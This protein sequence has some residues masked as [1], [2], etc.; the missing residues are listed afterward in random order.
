MPEGH[1]DHPS[2]KEL[3]DFG[4]GKLP[5]P[6]AD[7]VAAHLE[8][9]AECLSRLEGQRP[10]SFVGRLRDAAPKGSPATI[11]DA[12]AAPGGFP[13]ELLAMGKF[14]PLGQLGEGGMG[15]VWK[16]RHTFL[17]RLVAIK[18]MRPDVVSSPDARRR[19]LQEMRAG[20]RLGH[21][22]IAQTIDAAES[23]GLLYLV[24]EFV[25]GVSLDKLVS[26]RGP[27]PVGFACRCVVQAAQGLQHAHELGLVHRDVKPANLMVRKDK[28]VKVLDFGLARVPSEDDSARKTRYQVFLGTADY[29][30]PE[31]AKDARSAD[32]RSDIYS[33][34]CTLFFLLS[35]RP[36]FLGKNPYEVAAMHVAQAPAPLAGV[37]AG[38][39]AVVS[40]MMAKRREDRYQTPAEVIEALTPFAA[41]REPDSKP[42]DDSAIRT[43][44]PVTYRPPPLPDPSEDRP[45]LAPPERRPHYLAAALAGLALAAIAWGALAWKRGGAAEVEIRVDPPD[46]LVTVEGPQLSLTTRGDG[47]PIR[48]PVVPGEPY[49][50]KVEKPGFVTQTEPFVY[51]RGDAPVEVRLAPAPPPKKEGPAALP[52]PKAEAPPPKEEGPPDLRAAK[53]L[54]HDEFDDPKTSLP[55]GKDDHQERGYQDGRYFIQR[56]LGGLW[57]WNTPVPAPENFAV[58]VVGRAVGEPRDGWGVAITQYRNWTPTD[59]AE[60][61]KRSYGPQVELWRDGRCAV[62]PSFFATEKDSVPAAAPRRVDSA[63]G[64]DEWDTLLVVVR[65]RRVQVFVNGAEAVPPFQTRYL[66]SPSVIA[67]IGFGPGRHGRA[68]FERFT[69]YELPAPAPASAEPPRGEPAEGF[70]RLFN[71]QDTDGWEPILA[72]GTTGVSV[73]GGVLMLSHSDPKGQ[74]DYLVTRRRDYRD[75]HLRYQAKH[76]AGQA[77]AVLFRASPTT[78]GGLK[79]YNVWIGKYNIRLPGQEKPEL[80]GACNSALVSDQRGAFRLGAARPAPIEGDAWYQIDLITSGNRFQTL[81]NGRLVSDRDDEGWTFRQGAIAIDASPGKRA[82]YRDIEIKELPA[83]AGGDGDRRRWAYKKAAEGGEE[84]GVFQHVKDKRWVET[85]TGTPRIRRQE[86]TEAA[87]TADYVELERPGRVVRLYAGHADDGPDRNK[88]T[89]KALVGGWE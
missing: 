75:F 62:H 46:A 40:R 76:P 11:A 8:S 6:T 81:V 45:R 43:P 73:A 32:V 48:L 13:A 66:V 30:S 57:G 23:G 12:P 58:E 35:G 54:F 36:P 31:Q 80:R 71:G 20:G 16:A 2:A 33:L 79:G 38:L 39:W 56:H 85:A 74:P 29:V 26:R 53:R 14:E 69:L 59:S 49:S 47:R 64:G 77:G 87:R 42:S 5:R 83:V 7:T 37:P 51:H 50:L 86:F 82:E 41:R 72:P 4:L 10:D 68:E 1:A 22:N 61:R 18:V 78:A 3:S 89:P 25:E 70:V 88:L 28:T 21:P 65:G 19:F 34:G 27:L 24:M 17:D 52:T 67:L 63:R 55:V 84:W 15:A 60:P 9:C 44:V